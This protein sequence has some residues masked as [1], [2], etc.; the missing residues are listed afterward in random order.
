MVTE[1]LPKEGTMR[2]HKDYIVTKDEVHGYAN[3]WLA[4]SLKLEYVGQPGD[5]Q[6]SPSRISFYSGSIASFYPV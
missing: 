1:S 5:N 2:S 6:L 3:H 4:A